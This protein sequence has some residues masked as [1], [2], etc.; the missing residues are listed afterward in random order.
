MLVCSDSI[1]TVT[2]NVA[3]ITI[4]NYSCLHNNY[5]NDND[6]NDECTSDKTTNEQATHSSWGEKVISGIR[7]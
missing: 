6:E 4:N 1:V 2:A 3:N 5:H 7:L